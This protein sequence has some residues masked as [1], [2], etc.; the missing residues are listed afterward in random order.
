MKIELQECMEQIDASINKSYE[1]YDERHDYHK[2]ISEILEM[3]EEGDAYT[4]WQQYGTWIVLD[5]RPFAETALSSEKERTERM[6]NK[7]PTLTLVNVL[8]VYES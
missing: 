1:L 6:K 5:G 2:L 7:R 8:P 4:R 3:L